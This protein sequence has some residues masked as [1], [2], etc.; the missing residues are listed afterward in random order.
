MKARLDAAL[1][2]ETRDQ[3]R[4]EVLEE[5]LLGEWS[6]DI[7]SDKAFAD[8]AVFRMFGAPDVKGPVPVGWFLD[9]IHQDD[10]KCVLERWRTAIDTA[11][12]LDMEYRVVWPDG[13]IHWISVQTRMGVER[14]VRRIYGLDR[15]I[16]ARK[17]AEAALSESEYHFLE[18][19]NAMPQIVWTA[20]RNGHV[21]F[22]NHRWREMTGVD[23]DTDFER[24]WVNL[25]HPDDVDTRASA[26]REAL[27]EGTPFETEY[28]VWDRHHDA[29]RWFLG[30]G[31]P[32]FDENGKASRWYGTVTDVDE[33]K[34]VQQRV[35]ALN[36]SLGDRVRLRT[37]QLFESEQLMNL[38][39]EGIK[40]YAIVMLDPAGLI[41]TW[42]AG[43]ERLY[44]YNAAE[45]VGRNISTFYT[46][47]DV[48]A[49]L[50]AGAFALARE[51]G[52][53]HEEGLRVRRDGALRWVSKVTTPF[54]DETG[55]L[56]GFSTIA[57]DIT[58]SKKAM[59]DLLEAQQRADKANKAKSAFLA[60]MSH[61]I[62]T[63]MNAILGMS[64]VLWNTRLDAEQR[65]YVDTFRSAGLSLLSLINDIL[66]LSKI[67]SGQMALEHAPFD[68]G[69]LVKDAVDLFRPQAAEKGIRL[70]LE[71][72]PGAEIFV[73][74]DSSRLRQVLVNLLTN[75][76]KFTHFGEVTVTVSRP[77]AFKSAPVAIGFS[78]S[79][80]GIG[81]PASQIAA[82]FDDFSQGDSSTAR[83]Y[84]GTGLGL[85][86]CRRIVAKMG[87]QIEVESIPG[88]G[89]TFSFSVPFHQP[90][91]PARPEGNDFAAGSFNGQNADLMYPDAP[92][93]RL[94]ILIAEDND[95]N[96][97]LLKAYLCKTGHVLTLVEDGLSA[98][99]K[100]ECEEF[101]LVLMDV[102]MPK[103]DG[104]AATRAIR[105]RERV[106]KIDA[107]P[108]LALTADAGFGET[109][110]SLSAGC[111][112]H[113]TKPISKGTLL[114][115]IAKYARRRTPGANSCPVANATEARHGAK[116]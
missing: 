50:P 64:E 66:D 48:R 36:V 41:T 56:R 30:R 81:I 25:L 4:A 76:V 70:L 92:Q 18:L 61:E 86:I 67:E 19:A 59:A 33:M 45:A 2:P 12:N 10:R 80:T 5:W 104:L 43:A 68:L 101:D 58:E 3:Q 69:T 46:A 27:Q 105:E 84:G 26:L 110:R 40:D 28:R 31:I 100:V 75:A 55:Q 90:A 108:I 97:K 60:S 51:H 114:A 14:P 63:P 93:E 106:L 115:A 79:D 34:Q 1:V 87:A 37:S 44:G 6:L 11:A 20:T 113:L 7:D 91:V 38:M 96:Q 94:N 53:Y 102:R 57:Q 16:T 77:P 112:A 52:H 73:M 23:G 111:N 62:R 88:E 54:R 82:I 65:E 109:E 83:K 47:E 35:E 71:L 24:S 32:R 78:V 103:M 13:G 39:V 22:V 29:Y 49:G 98:V 9:R 89:S 99:E 116:A 107:L 15:D 17:L 85:G 72:S 8:P 21:D 42:N 74:G 95:K